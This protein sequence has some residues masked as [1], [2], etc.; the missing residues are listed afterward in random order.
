MKRRKEEEEEHTTPPFPLDALASPLLL[1]PY[2]T[3]P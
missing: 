3:L 1:R 2:L